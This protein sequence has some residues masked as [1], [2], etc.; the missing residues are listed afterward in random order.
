MNRQ[1]SSA[2]VYLHFYLCNDSVCEKYPEGRGKLHRTLSG[3]FH[4]RQF[5]KQLLCQGVQSIKNNEFLNIL[6]AHYSRHEEKHKIQ[7]NIRKNCL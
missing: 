1:Q 4:I 2:F 3:S 5:Y 6:D 7:T